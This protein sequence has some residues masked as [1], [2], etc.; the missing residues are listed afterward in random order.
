MEKTIRMNLLFD[1][2]GPLLTER[3]QDIYQMYFCEDLSLSEVG[4]QL[5]ISRQAVYD[6]LKRSSATLEEFEAKLKLVEKHKMQQA[7]LLNIQK[8]LENIKNQLITSNLT[9]VA[10]QISLIQADIQKIITES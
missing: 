1:F 6:V 2:Y 4:E 8:Q 10:E 5:D 3:Q 9:E 7:A